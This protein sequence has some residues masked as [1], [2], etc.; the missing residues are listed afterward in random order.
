MI[1]SGKGDTMI[2]GVPVPRRRFTRWAALYFVGYFVAP[3]LTL[4]FLVDLALY[5]LATEVLGTC[6]AVL[7]FFE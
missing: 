2:S 1:R 7:C 3:F 5:L 6:Y 4:C